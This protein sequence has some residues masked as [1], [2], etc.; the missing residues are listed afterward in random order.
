MLPFFFNEFLIVPVKVFVS[1][2][3]SPRFI[4]DDLLAYITPPIHRH[5][6][7][8]VFHVEVDCNSVGEDKPKI[9]HLLLSG[10]DFYGNGYIMMFVHSISF[11]VYIN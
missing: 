7:A 2:L 8:S 3:S 4:F 6:D 11:L 1:P 5:F 9:F 10:I